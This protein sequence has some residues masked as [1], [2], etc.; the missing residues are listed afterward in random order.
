MGLVFCH[1]SSLG[2][3]H[4]FLPGLYLI[5][6]CLSCHRKHVVFGKLF[7]GQDTLKKIESVEVD[8]TRP[9]VPVKIVDC[10]EFHDIKHHGTVVPVQENGKLVFCKLSWVSA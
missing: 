4:E 1:L 2:I 8:G 3:F 7:L 9:V 10:G 6:L 5:C